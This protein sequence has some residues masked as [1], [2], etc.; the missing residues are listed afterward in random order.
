MTK[1]PNA[2]LRRAIFW[3]LASPLV[4][5]LSPVRLAAQPSTTQATALLAQSLAALTRGTAV[6]DVQL[7][8]NV[9]YVAGSDEE[10][11]PATLE[12]LADL[13]SRVALSLS[14]GQRTWIQNGVRASYAGANGQQQILPLHN[15]LNPA[16]WFF[17]P[18]F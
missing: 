1:L 14:G 16:P 12:A 18:P 15:S 8:A 3:L 5:A 2:P 9:N 10:T 6:A 13:E 17:F 7:Q 11:G 4:L